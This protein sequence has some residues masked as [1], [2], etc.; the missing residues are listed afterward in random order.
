ME[1]P[2]LGLAR[3]WLPWLG[4]AL[5]SAILSAQPFAA[6]SVLARWSAVLAFFSLA[7]AWEKDER[8]A[9]L[10]TIMAASAVLA[11]AALWTGA[12][13]GFR[14]EMTGLLPPYYNYTTFA[15][16]AGAAAGAVWALHPRTARGV[17]RWAGFVV[18]GLGAICLALAHGRGAQLGVLVAAVVW[19]ARRWGPKA[20]LAGLAVL[21]LAL[22]AVQTNLL[23]A[24][25]R[26]DVVHHGTRYQGARP[27][28]WRGAAA[29][30]DEN[31]WFGAGPGSFGAAFRLHPA[32]AKGMVAARWGME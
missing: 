1:R 10:K 29:I 21:I 22:G 8:E 28:I 15:L 27:D 24:S 7:A 2:R 6:V 16:S 31:R 11:A 13:R 5:L 17:S 30:A 12:G 4:F 25:W 26:A 9:W 3:Y 18:A 32:E 20:G 19:A 23:P 14:A